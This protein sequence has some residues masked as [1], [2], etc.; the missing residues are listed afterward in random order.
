M[1]EGIL[2]PYGSCVHQYKNAIAAL[3]PYSLSLTPFA[4]DRNSIG[5]IPYAA[6]DIAKKADVVTIP[7]WRHGIPWAVLL[8]LG[9]P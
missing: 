2:K 3:T 6:P 8:W 5:T 9:H 7:G 1:N 4:L